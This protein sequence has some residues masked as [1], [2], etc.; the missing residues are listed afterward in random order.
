[1]YDSQKTVLLYI[2]V[3]PILLQVCTFR[4]VPVFKAFCSRALEFAH[5]ILGRTSNESVHCEHVIL[6]I[7]MHGLPDWLPSAIFRVEI[8]D[9]FWCLVFHCRIFVFN[10]PSKVSPFV[11]NNVVYN[12][13]VQ[14]DGTCILYNVCVC[15]CMC[16]VCVCMCVWVSVCVCVYVC[17]YV[18]MYLYIAL[19][20]C[21]RSN[22]H[23]KHQPHV[24]LRHVVMNVSVYISI[25]IL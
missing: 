22:Q 4:I 23:Y 14:H 12:I 17:M 7:A 20:T 15:V 21:T 25:L 11:D 24:C 1:V 8:Y 5:C 6:E 2:E 3:I 16:G 13:V 19:L 10:S 9:L 18:C